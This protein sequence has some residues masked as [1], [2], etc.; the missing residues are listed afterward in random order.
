VPTNIA[1]CRLVPTSILSWCSTKGIGVS[2]RLV[3]ANIE[4]VGW[5]LQALLSWC[6]AEE[7]GVSCRLVPANIVIVGWCLHDIIKISFVVFSHLGFHVKSLCT[8]DCMVV[9][10]YH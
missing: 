5:C 1:S 4:V 3:P 2:C 8:V 9:Y 7:I 10:I 6:S